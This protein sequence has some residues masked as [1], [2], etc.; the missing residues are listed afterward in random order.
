M[1]RTKSDTVSLSSRVKGATEKKLQAIA[2]ERNI[3][4]RTLTS[5]ILERFADNGEDYLQY[6]MSEAQLHLKTYKAVIHT[7]NILE[8][9]SDRLIDEFDGPTF[10]DPKYEQYRE[11][12][13]GNKVKVDLSLKD[14]IKL[15][16]ALNT[17]WLSDP[18]NTEK[19]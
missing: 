4:L 1:A 8:T 11:D 3:P 16:A 2:D 19:V 14:K 17:S 18:N 15:R 7:R 9:L 12:E 6:K 10:N 5:E 13:N